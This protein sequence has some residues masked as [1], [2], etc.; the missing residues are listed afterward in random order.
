MGLLLTMLLSFINSVFQLD[1]QEANLG[2]GSYRSYQRNLSA[3]F[4]FLRSPVVVARTPSVATM[5]AI[6]V[7]KKKQIIFSFSS[8]HVNFFLTFC[9]GGLSFCGFERHGAPHS[10]TISARLASRTSNSLPNKHT[11]ERSS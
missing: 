5:V 11:L 3:N 7:D 4:I 1:Y 2:I 6:S 9:A 8:W 10:P